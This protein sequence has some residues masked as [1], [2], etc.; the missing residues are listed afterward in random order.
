V[1]GV[2]SSDQEIVAAREFYEVG[3]NTFWGV[4]EVSLGAPSKLISYL[5]VVGDL[6]SFT[7]LP[8]GDVHVLF[9]TRQGAEQVSLP[10]AVARSLDFSPTAIL[11]YDVVTSFPGHC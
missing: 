8:S 10:L 9:R 2:G 5:Q 4:F 11:T 3:R 6:E 1:K 7:P